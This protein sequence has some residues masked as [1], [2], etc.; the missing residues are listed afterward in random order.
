MLKEVIRIA[1][2]LVPPARGLDI[3]SLSADTTFANLKFFEVDIAQFF[4][5]LEEM[6]GPVK[7]ISTEE[8]AGLT[9]LG[10]VAEFLTARN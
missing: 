7:P 1:F 4:H 8:R 10:A 9:T 3:A 5:D 2:S 6:D